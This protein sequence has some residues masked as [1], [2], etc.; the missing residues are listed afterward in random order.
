MRIKTPAS[1]GLSEIDLVIGFHLTSTLIAELA[2]PRFL[3]DR[4]V[5][6]SL[7]GLSGGRKNAFYNTRY[8]PS[9]K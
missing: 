4:G 1:A 7:R 9:E 2:W 5:K 3:N 6:F 8:Q